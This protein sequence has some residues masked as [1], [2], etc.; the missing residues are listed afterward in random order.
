MGSH[1]RLLLEVLSFSGFSTP[2]CNMAVGRSVFCAKGES[3]KSVVLSLAGLLVVG[4]VFA[5]VGDLD[6]LRGKYEAAKAKIELDC[7]KAKETAK[8]GYGTALAVAMASYKK[9]GNLEAYLA[10]E[11]VKKQFDVD[12]K[13]PEDGG[14]DLAG[15][16]RAYR[17]AVGKA[18]ADALAK[19]YSLNQGYAFQLES[20]IKQ[21]MQADKI[22]EAKKA[23]EELS[24]VKFELADLEVRQ[25]KT[26]T[27]KTNG[28]VE[29][30][31]ETKEA[32]VTGGKRMVIWNTHN[33][34]HNNLGTLSC[35]VTLYSVTKAVWEKKGIEVPW[36]PGTDC[37]VSID[38]PAGLRFDRVRVNITKWVG[39]GGGLSE[40]QVF[41][42][43]KNIAE[44]CRA[45]ASGFWKDGNGSHPPERLTDGNTSSEV[46]AKGYW[47]LPDSQPGW[48]EIDLT[49]KVRK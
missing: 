28:A 21:F 23:N 25:L 36:K 34:Q 1:G 31:Q 27:V 35:D 8:V 49:K 9:G 17:D 7:G 12:G 30:E 3:M 45:T 46:F 38:V 22:D 2:F 29:I 41:D 4:S 10:V 26:E 16:V 15:A 20:L 19:V 40:I 39:L 6:T 14:A 33:A 42:G 48:A 32:G 5:Q 37:S 44:H 43:R 11:K 18:D 24:R 13:V 47:L